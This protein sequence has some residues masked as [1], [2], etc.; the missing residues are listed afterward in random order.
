[1][2]VD[3]T[4]IFRGTHF[5]QSVQ[6]S[7]PF[8]KMVAVGGGAGKLYSGAPILARKI[9][10]RSNL[11]QIRP[12]TAPWGVGEVRHIFFLRMEIRLVKICLS[13]DK[14]FVV[15]RTRDHSKPKLTKICP[16]SVENRKKASFG[17][18]LG[19]RPNFFYTKR[20]NSSI[21]TFFRTKVF[22]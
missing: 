5:F 2:G 17:S 19:V 14:T 12:I 20:L 4:E 11:P 1:M 13:C 21:P 9:K 22:L 15:R 10:K 18:L 3:R 6:C 7:R 8:K 16:K